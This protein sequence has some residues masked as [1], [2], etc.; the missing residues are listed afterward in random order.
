MK[1]ANNVIR[2]LAFQEIYMRILYSF[3]TRIAYVHMWVAQFFS[4][5]MR[6]FIQG[7]IYTFET[8][9]K[10]ID[11]K[12]KTIWFHCASLGEFEQGVPIMEAVRKE[13]AD[14]KI[15]VSFFSPSGFEVK[16]NT[17]LADV[18]VYLPMDTRQNA[19]RFVKTIHPSLVIFVKYEFWPNY[20]WALSKKKAPTI[21]VSG[22]FRR[23]QAFFK[24][25][26]GFMRRALH[27]FEHIFVQDRVSKELLKQ[28][29]Y[30]QV[31]ISGDTRFDRVSHQIEQDNALDFMEQ[32]KGNSLC[33]VF[34]ST[35]PEDE[36]VL[37]G[38]IN[39]SESTVKYVI[40][41]HKIE[42]SKIDAFRK[43]ITKPS[44][45]YSEKKGKDLS[46][47]QVLIVD[48]VGLLT[49]IYSYGDI[50]FVGGAMGNTGLHNILE[51]ATFGIPIIIGK[52]YST[53][54]EAQRLEQLAGLFSIHSSETYIKIEQK[55]VADQSFRDKTG[56]ICGH[57]VNQN[58]GATAKVME[59]LKDLKAAKRIK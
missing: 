10:H 1:T 37:L 28:L 57:F 31:T 17:P 14:H 25:Y 16:K 5:K 18:V 23:D 34:G 36:A 13:F 56:M 7:R 22:L 12:D 58:T 20:L 54:P 48:T 41:P 39:R 52:N 50:A 3:L 43:K 59:Y 53:F 9:E 47:Y 42:V 46:E 19:A 11:P 26:G 49:K 15:V 45:L 2:I 29:Q 40:A 8:I 4:K 30:T 6:Q 21:L 33:V 32:F 55:L 24:W 38:A 51:P 35:W 27:R 44:V